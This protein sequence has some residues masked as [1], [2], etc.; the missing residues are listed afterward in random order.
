MRP[1]EPAG[2]TSGWTW[3]QLTCHVASLQSL[4]CEPVGVDPPLWSLAFEWTFYFLAPLILGA[5]Y[6]PMHVL[7]RFAVLVLL[8]AGLKTLFGSVA[9]FLPMLAIWF[10]GAVSARIVARSRSSGRARMVR[11]RAYRRRHGA[12]AC[13]RCPAGGDRRG[14]RRRA[15]ALRLPSRPSRNLPVAEPLVG[16][17]A[18]FSFSLYVLHVP[19]GLLIGASLERLGWPRDLGAPGLA[20][21]SAFGLTVGATL[22]AA[23]LFAQLT[24]RNTGVG[25][26]A[27]G[28]PARRTPL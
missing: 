14:H 17:G 2:I 7:G 28:T 24:E 11:P 13:P 4:A 1:L 10:L 12:I 26:A 18:A 27:A 5:L 20:S 16:R 23:F 22:V 9:T 3:A 8:L 21:Y 6:A 25:E 19:V 15:L